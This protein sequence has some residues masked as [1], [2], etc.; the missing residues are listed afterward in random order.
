M[1]TLNKY[2][3]REYTVLVYYL[4]LMETNPISLRRSQMDI[5]A[6]IL[7]A[8]TEEKRKT[9]IMHS[10]NLSLKQLETY[11]DLL[12]DKRLLREISEANSNSSL[13]ELTD[14]GKNF[15]DAYT[16]LK[17]LLKA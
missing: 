1:Y 2:S 17:A 10:C 14:K 3:N 7:L 9:N 13:L 4:V 8:T 12:L 6:D 16:D 11:W 5:I 15:V